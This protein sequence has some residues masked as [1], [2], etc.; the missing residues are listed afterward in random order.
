MQSQY[1]QYLNKGSQR[2]VDG[3]NR[4]YYSELNQYYSNNAFR[5]FSIKLPVQGVVNYKT[6][7]QDFSIF[8]GQFLLISKQPG[9]VFFDSSLLVK[10][11]CI[12][13][14]EKTFSEACSVLSN[15]KLNLDNLEAGYFNSALFFEN[16]YTLQSDT[17]SKQLSFIIQAVQHEPSNSISAETFFS[18]AE[19]IIPH[20]YNHCSSIKA[21]SGIKPSTKKEILRR[22]LNGKSYIDI[23]FLQNPEVNV[24]AKQSN[25]SPFHFFRSFKQAFGISPYQYMLAKR[26]EHA[27]TLIQQGQM[28][29]DVAAACS[30][31]DIFSFSK[32][33]K[34]KYKQPPSIYKRNVVV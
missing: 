28:L 8:P 19:S 7:E 29:D 27:L 25:L 21:L 14:N 33:F 17:L 22:L 18:L 10:S 23:N 16:V 30:F 31:P 13:I 32:A 6:D 12:D 15:N 3:C 2:V 4:I 24:I 1:Y 20:Q 5:N 26:L 11:I 34:R 9:K